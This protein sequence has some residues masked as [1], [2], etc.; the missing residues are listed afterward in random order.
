[1]NS[2]TMFDEIYNNY[3]NLGECYN[4]KFT[5]CERLQEELRV[6]QRARQELE[7]N[8]STCEKM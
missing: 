7:N 4:E 3:K 5:E 2:R 8:L 1:M 6:S